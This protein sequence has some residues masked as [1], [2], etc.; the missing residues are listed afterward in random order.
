V[1]GGVFHRVAFSFTL[2]SMAELQ[3]TPLRATRRACHTLNTPD[4]P[5]TKK[6]RYARLEVA[7]AEKRVAEY[8]P[9]SA[10]AGGTHKDTAAGRVAPSS[11]NHDQ[12]AS[13]RT[14]RD[15]PPTGSPS[16]SFASL[17]EAACAEADFVSGGECPSPNSV[18]STF[19]TATV[20]TAATDTS[21]SSQSAHLPSP[22]GLSLFTERDILME[23]RLRDLIRLELARI[24][25]SPG[26]NTSVVAKG[27]LHLGAFYHLRGCRHQGGRYVRKAWS[28]Y[29][30]FCRHTGKDIREGATK[31]VANLRS[32][33]VA[34]LWEDFCVIGHVNEE[35]AA[36][37]AA[38]KA[39]E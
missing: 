24:R 10:A 30:R 35:E 12:P 23:R 11:R 5:P 22:G 1:Q 37:A 6:R 25:T 36:V 13:K 20:H 27:M 8:L 7:E 14:K 32:L 26:R 17:V 19:R 33:G 18:Y 9:S 4:S 3:T 38:K 29:R 28:I 15:A 2:A 16:L 39:K 21:Q 34:D 31:F